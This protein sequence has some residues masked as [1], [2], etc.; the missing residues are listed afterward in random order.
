MPSLTFY[1]TNKLK[2]HHSSF[3]SF[4]Q[5]MANRLSVGFYRYGPNSK[6]QNYL[7]RI[8]GAIAHY[9]DTG[10]TEFLIDAANYCWLEFDLPSHP[11]AHFEC[12]DSHG[13]NITLVRE[14]L[15]PWEYRREGD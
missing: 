14:P 9:D 4:V 7:R 12:S 13:K 2:R 15:R 5:M 11:R 1:L 8:K 10:N 3:T 6:K